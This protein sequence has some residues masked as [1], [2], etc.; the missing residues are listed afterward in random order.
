MN[1]NIAGT[2]LK[3][4]IP[5]SLYEKYQKFINKKTHKYGPFT[6]KITPTG[7]GSSIKLIHDQTQDEIDL[8]DY[9]K[10]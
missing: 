7:I 6:V 4:D 1:V 3:M 8:T 10:W 5:K 2:P 9:T